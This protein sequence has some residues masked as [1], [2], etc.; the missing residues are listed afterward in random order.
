MC[1]E[2]INALPAASVTPETLA[3]ASP[4]TKLVIIGC[5]E[6]S[7]IDDYRKRIGCP[8][9]VYADPTRKLYDTLGMITTL[10]MGD[11]RPDYQQS[12]TVG[13]VAGSFVAALSGGIG[14][15]T[16][17]GKLSQVGGEFLFEHGKPAWCHRMQ[18]TRGHIEMKGLKALLHLP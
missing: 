13:I 11:V 6:P 16:K 3:A 8:F 15:F 4:P 14:S 10:D 5:G 1:Q 7:L 18:N 2:F 12:S 17:A 9:D